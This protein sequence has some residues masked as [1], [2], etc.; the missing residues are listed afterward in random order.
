M[1]SKLFLFLSS[2][3]FLF[4]SLVSCSNDEP[5]VAQV[6]QVVVFDYGDDESVPE[7]RLAV[8]L[9][10]ESDVHYASK[11]TVKNEAE[12]YEWLQGGV[13]KL[14]GVSD[15]DWAYCVNLVPPDGMF[16]SQGSY[17]V[18]YEDSAEKEVSST[19]N[20]FY[21]ENLVDSRSGD[22]PQILTCQFFR[23]VA[24][25]SA[26][27]VLLYFGERKAEWD[28]DEFIFQDF[29]NAATV[30][31]VYVMNTDTVLC[32]MPPVDLHNKD[33]E[34]TS[35]PSSGEGEFNFAG[36]LDSAEENKEE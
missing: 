10:M 32:L 9:S 3:A 24:I 21:Q 1:G 12:G 26:D 11:I 8:F 15:R 31:D 4:F 20:L 34:K 30:R 17:T 18:V 19:F 25:Y 28:Y 22:F 33:F 23:K 14:Q 16:I 6:S 27:D 35:E 7:Q 5:D 13:R 36:I 29:S 2:F